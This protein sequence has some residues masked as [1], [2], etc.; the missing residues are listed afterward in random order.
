MSLTLTPAYSSSLLNGI[1]EHWIVQIDNSAS[2]YIRLSTKEF[3][4]V[5]S[6]GYHGYIINKPTIRENID[7][8]SSSSSVSNI[9]LTCLNKQ[10]YNITG[11]PKLS[12]EI[13]GGSAYYINRDVTIYSRLDSTNDLLIYTGRLKSVSQN[14]DETVQLEISARTPIDFLKVPLY[15]SKSGNFFPILYGSGTSVTSTVSNPAFVQY[16]PAKCFPLM[17]DSINDDGYNCLA[18]QA[19]TDGK[20]HYPIKDTYSSGGFPLFVSLNDVQN[21]SKNNYEGATN[22]TN[23]NVLYSALDLH[24]SYYLRPTQG[25]TN[26]ATKTKEI[27]ASPSNQDKFYDNSS[28]TFGEWEIQMDNL[29][30]PPDESLTDT[31]TWTYSIKDIVREEHDIQECKLYIKWKISDYSETPSMTLLGRLRVAPTYGGSTNNVI[32]TTESGNRTTNTYEVIDLLNTSTFS[33]ANGQVPDSIDI[34]FES[35]GSIPADTFASPGSMTFEAYDLYLEITT[36]ITDTES[37]ANSSAVNDVETLY[38]GTSGLKRSWDTS[39]TVSNIVEMHRDLL[40]RFGGITTTPDNFSTL[41]AKRTNWDIYYYLHEQ[42]TLQELLDQCQKEGGF[43]FRF[44]ASNGNPQYIFINDTSTTNHTLT[45]DDISNI[46]IRINEFDSLI[47]KRIIKHQLNPINDELLFEVECTDTTNNPRTNYNV[48]SNENTTSEE[49]EILVGNIVNSQDGQTITNTNMGSGNKNDGYAN[50]YNAI[51][52]VP[53]IIVETEVVNPSFY[54]MEVGDIVE[55]DNTSQITAPFGDSFS[56][57]QFI[58][59]SLTRSIGTL[60]IILREI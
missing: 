60:K 30:S 37:L 18:H 4:D 3:G 29:A 49:L 54:S 32:I 9:T 43:I 59:T 10:I 20:L 40:Y 12:E 31:E 39:N 41:N 13:F 1:D 58:L 57:K 7:L 28:T 14:N 45:K 53:K 33:S 26:V 24:R 8:A 55:F 2:G 19:T 51:Q 42:K 47:T 17:V 48:Q 46:T 44:K 50:Y 22:D 27:P 16:T 21:S 15:S 34:I 23:R 11:D 52:G 6:T 35:F 36:K 56:G 25:I 38:T 5:N